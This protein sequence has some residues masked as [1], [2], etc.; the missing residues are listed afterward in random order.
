MKT[1]VLNVAHVKLPNM[2]RE[3]QYGSPHHEAL[4]M[5]GCTLWNG[6]HHTEVPGETRVVETNLAECWG[7]C[8]QT[9]LRN[10]SQTDVLIGWE[11]H[12]TKWYTLAFGPMLVKQFIVN[13]HKPPLCWLF[14][15]PICRKVGGWFTIVLPKLFIFCPRGIPSFQI[16]V[17][18]PGYASCVICRVTDVA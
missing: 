2:F 16:S 10:K 4:S 13:H 18:S 9:W 1:R 5:F 3:T 15:Q 7:R 6:G 17:A 8:H 12:R 11:N 14:V